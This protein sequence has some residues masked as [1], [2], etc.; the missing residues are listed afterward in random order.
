M[1]SRGRVPSVR[2][3]TTK[4]KEIADGETN[5]QAKVIGLRRPVSAG[6][7]ATPGQEATTM[8]F[9]GPLRHHPRNRQPALTGHGHIFIGRRLSLVALASLLALALGACG[10]SAAS[11]SE[12]PPAAADTTG[13]P[14]VAVQDLAYTPQRLTVPAGAAVTWVWRDGAIAHDVKGDGFRSQVITEGTFRHRFTQPGTYDYLCTLH[15]N[16]TGVIEVTR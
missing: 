3:S 6:D 11:E 9:P 4:G 15:P 2:H 14:T 16:M 12:A 8:A 1:P 13:G 10:T 7:N 5:K